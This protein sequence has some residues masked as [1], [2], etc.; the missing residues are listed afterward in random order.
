MTAQCFLFTSQQMIATL[1]VTNTWRELFVPMQVMC[2]VI[3]E[4]K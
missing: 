2:S 4:Q 1:H 3:K